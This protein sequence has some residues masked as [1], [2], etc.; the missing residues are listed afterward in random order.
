MTQNPSRDLSWVKEMRAKVTSRAAVPHYPEADEV[1]LRI[2]HEE[3][4]IKEV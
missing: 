3:C 4:K 1:S 2:A